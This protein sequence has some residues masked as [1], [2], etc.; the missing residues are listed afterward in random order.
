MK[1]Y[2]S[3]SPKATR[4]VRILGHS[5]FHHNFLFLVRYL[6]QSDHVGLR[7]TEVSICLLIFLSF[8]CLCV[9]RVIGD[10]KD[11]PA[12]LEEQDERYANILYASTPRPR[13]NT[14]SFQFESVIFLFFYNGHF[15]FY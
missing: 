8:L 7:E 4:A 2:H 9:Y 1:A 14:L 3:D 6:I 11:L 15:D 5:T 10:R 12:S 13:W